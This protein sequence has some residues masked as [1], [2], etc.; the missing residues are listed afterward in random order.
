MM[1]VL[2]Q[3]MSKDDDERITSA[4]AVHCHDDVAV[5][6][7]LHSDVVHSGHLTWLSW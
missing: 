7:W 1:S 3:L 2:R 5:M 4:A 6:K